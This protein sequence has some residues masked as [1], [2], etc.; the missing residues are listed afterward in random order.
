MTSLTGALAVRRT[1]IGLGGV[2]VLGLVGAVA[3]SRCTARRHGA[4][5]Y[6]STCGWAA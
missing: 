5:A 4:R 1:P 3:A 6:R 2:A